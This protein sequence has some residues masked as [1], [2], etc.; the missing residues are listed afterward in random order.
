MNIRIL[1]LLFLC[2]P[3]S[4]LFATETE[5]HAGNPIVYTID[6]KQEIDRS[7]QLFLS[8]GLKEAAAL[9]AD[10]VLI[11]MN[12]YGGLVDAADSMRT[13]IL[14]SPIPVYVY[15]DN[16]AASAGALISI[17]CKKIFMRKGANIGAATVVNQVGS[18]M[19]DKYQS[20]MRSMMRATA[21][22]HGKDTLLQRGDT[23]YKWKRD[24]LIAEAMVD[25]RTVV[26]GLIDST[27]VLSF[28]AEEAMQWGFCDGM[29]E[30]VDEVITQQLGFSNY[31]KKSYEPTWLVMMKGFL[32]SPALQSILI[33]VI[34]AGIYFELQTP[35]VG[36]PSLAALAAAILYFAPL[37]IDGLAQNWEILIFVI[38][39]ILIALE[40]FVIP[41]FGL[42]G[43]AGILC[44]IFGLTI[45]LIDNVDFTFEGVTSMETGK[46]A[47]TVLVGLGLSFFLIIWF[48]SRIGNSGLFRRV[49][50]QTDLEGALSSPVLSD[51]IGRV[52]ETST[53]LRPSGKVMIDGEIY[54]GISECGFIEKGT[55]VKVIRF[56]NAQ[57]YVLKA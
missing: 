24:P 23:I 11:H 7:T 43:I 41:G 47:L 30:S 33:L 18:E 39:L 55:A 49:A 34:F 17:A 1:F 25:E 26:P 32:M 42:P 57:V 38:G 8:N 51:L 4:T 50:L 37:Y 48:S 10:A 12:T 44:V 31:Q 3:V 2:L 21:E 19:P 52:G 13:A 46:A 5:Q 28:T 9:D 27:K 35:G 6:I 36:F 22:A 54:D 45:S 53:V 20:Y 14:Y 15:I 56:E 40:I 16:N 29:A